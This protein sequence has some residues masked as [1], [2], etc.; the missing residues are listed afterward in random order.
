MAQS[1]K[2]LTLGVHSGHDLMVPESELCIGLWVR[3]RTDSA[4]PAWDS[5]SFSLCLSLS[6]SKEIK[7]KK[8]SQ[9]Q[10]KKNPNKQTTKAKINEYDLYVKANTTLTK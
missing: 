2:C 8:K 5:L 6:L 10:D 1:V 3:L 7:L 9:K 4:E